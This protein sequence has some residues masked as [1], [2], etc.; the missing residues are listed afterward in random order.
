MAST[1]IVMLGIVLAVL[2]AVLLYYK[3][4]RLHR[5]ETLWNGIAVA[6]VVCGFVVLRDGLTGSRQILWM[7]PSEETQVSHAPET[8]IGGWDQPIP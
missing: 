5:C 4:A 8:R 6:L 7:F 3:R 2:G 1:P